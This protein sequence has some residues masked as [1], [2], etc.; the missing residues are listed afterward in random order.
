LVSLLYALGAIASTEAISIVA[1][2]VITGASE[3]SEVSVDVDVTDAWAT[4]SVEFKSTAS[5]WVS[6]I[7]V[8]QRAIL[9]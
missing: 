3:K 6:L 7:Q 8:L 5:R 4:P 9:L 1:V 2:I